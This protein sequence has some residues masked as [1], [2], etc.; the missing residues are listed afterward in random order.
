MLPAPFVYSDPY[1]RRG[2]E[3]LIETFMYPPATGE[4]GTM[5]PGLIARL[6]VIAAQ[7]Q[8]LDTITAGRVHTAAVTATAGLWAVI[9]WSEYQHAA[10]A[11]IAAALT[12]LDSEPEGE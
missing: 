10:V 6:D 9:D 12:M 11:A 4:R 1:Y 7:V 2:T 5:D 3:K 8:T